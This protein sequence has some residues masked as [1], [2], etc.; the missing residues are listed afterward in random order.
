MGKAFSPQGKKTEVTR[1]WRSFF[2]LYGSRDPF[3][4]FAE[5]TKL[6]TMVTAAHLGE[7]CLGEAYVM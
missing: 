1:L 6:F 4:L 5:V 2:S 3:N 7:G